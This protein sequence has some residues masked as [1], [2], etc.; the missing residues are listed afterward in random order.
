[1]KQRYKLDTPG[2]NPPIHNK[3]LLIDELKSLAGEKAISLTNTVEEIVS[4]FVVVYRI[5]F[6][7]R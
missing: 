4:T 7:N 5:L 2:M 1:M 6:K 3:E